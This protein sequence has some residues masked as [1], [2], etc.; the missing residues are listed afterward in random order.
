MSKSRLVITTGRDFMQT[1]Q[2]AKIFPLCFS[3][4]FPFHVLCEMMFHKGGYLRLQIPRFVIDDMK[5]KRPGISVTL[6]GSL[7]DLQHH[8]DLL[9]VQERLAV[10]HRT[11]GNIG[12]GLLQMVE[13]AHDPFHP[14]KKSF[15]VQ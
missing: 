15:F 9:I 7:A 11:L 3:L 13:T 10:E 5:R 1:K 12:N 14:F 6:Q 8:T 2:K 4:T